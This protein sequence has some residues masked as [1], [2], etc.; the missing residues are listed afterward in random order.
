M[1]PSGGLPRSSFELKKPLVACQTQVD[2]RGRV[3]L[4]ER[5]RD[6]ETDFSMSPTLV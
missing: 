3:R 2:Q 6:L 5:S 1:T 4:E